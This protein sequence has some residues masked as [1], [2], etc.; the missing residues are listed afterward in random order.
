MTKPRL[1]YFDFSGSRGEEC[2]LAL[3]LNGVEFEDNR[4]KGAQWAELKPTTPYGSL[5]LLEVDGRPPLA[6][7]NAI[8]TFIG[9]TFGLHPKDPWDAAR[10][11]A[12]FAAVEEYRAAAIPTGATKDEAEKKRRREAFAAGYIQKWAGNLERQ[13]VGPFLD[14]DTLHIA[15]LKMFMIVESLVSGA[16]DYIDGSVFADFPKLRGLHAAVSEHPEVAQWRSR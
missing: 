6:Q 5:P 10:H 9:R 4:I 1:T 16:I 11:E 14:G 7:S 2:R 3:H 15:D 8:L 13:I 12:V